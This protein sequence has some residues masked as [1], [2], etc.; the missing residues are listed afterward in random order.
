LGVETRTGQALGRDVTVAGL[1]ADGYEAVLLTTGGWDSRLATGPAAAPV[2]AVAGTRLLID[3][4]RHRPDADRP[5]AFDGDTI[6]YGGGALALA[7]A[8]RCLD[9]GAR[10]ATVVL[11]EKTAPKAA[12]DQAG[13]AVL[14]GMAVDALHGTA[15]ALTG[16]R[17]RNLETGETTLVEARHLVLAAGRLPQL[18]F[19]A[20]PPDETDATSPP[21]GWTAVSPYKA[22]LIAADGVGIFSEADVLSDFPAAIKAIAS[23]RRLA[24]SAHHL[25]KNER[26]TLADNVLTPYTLVQD[27]DHVEAVAPVAREIMPLCH[28]AQ[29]NQALELEQGFDEARARRE[30]ARCLQCGLI[31]YRHTAEGAGDSLAPAEAR[32]AG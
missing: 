16:L 8:R 2:P 3:V 24:A 1:L 20:D 6:I 11:R 25:I 28:E 7:A 9:L 32:P 12:P 5:M 23:G 14:T 27:I 15:E 4:M 26:L 31:C 21:A 29:F 10:R 22:P 13:I 18:I 19:R 30:A 17:L